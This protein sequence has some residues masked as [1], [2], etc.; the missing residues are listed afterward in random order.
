M[1]HKHW[2]YLEPER[3]LLA[4]RD[5]V[6]SPAHFIL[7]S[8]ML[9][10]FSLSDKSELFPLNPV[11]GSSTF[12]SSTS[13]TNIVVRCVH[14]LN[15]GIKDEDCKI[16]FRWSIRLCNMQE[17]VTWD[18]V[19]SETGFDHVRHSFPGKNPA[20]ASPLLKDKT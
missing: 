9:E 1:R 4:E 17:C 14:M 5:L 10:D 15:V 6:R 3:C 16:I 8:C 12:S 7:R 2:L 13:C 19:R 11:S 18:H 20:L